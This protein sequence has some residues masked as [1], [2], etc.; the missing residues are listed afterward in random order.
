MSLPLRLSALPSR[1]IAATSVVPAANMRLPGIESAVSAARPEASTVLLLMASPRT[2]SL[3]R[4]LRRRN[5]GQ[6]AVHTNEFRTR[7]RTF[8]TTA[9]G[10]EEV[11]AGILN[12]HPLVRGGSS[13]SQIRV[14]SFDITQCHDR[15]V[16][17]LSQR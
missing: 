5:C 4:V 13:L 8:A 7:G 12:R 11:S 9:L 6:A 15:T 1:P 3:A 14:K 17:K 2:T 10:L 16:P